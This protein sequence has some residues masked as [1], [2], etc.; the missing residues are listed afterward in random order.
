MLAVPSP[1]CSSLRH[2]AHGKPSRTIPIKCISCTLLLFAFT[3]R[4]LTAQMVPSGP[5]ANGIGSVGPN[6]LRVRQLDELSNE[7]DQKRIMDEPVRQRPPLTCI[8]EP[9]PGLSKTVSVHSLQVPE[10]VQNEYER[11]CTALRSK[12]LAESEKHLRKAVQYSPDAFG[13]VMLG[14][15]LEETERWD[16]ARN[17]CIEGVVHDP[18][19]WPA[20]ICLAEIDA[21]T[22]RW[23]ASLDESDRAVSLSL[24]SKRFAYFVSALALFNL[25]QVS[26]AESRALEAKRLDVDHQ[27]PPLHL[28]LAQIDELKG[29]LR[30]AETELHDCLKYAKDS[31]AGD[32]A[33]QEL[34]RLDSAAK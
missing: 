26:E 3:G 6:D 29:D 1:R 15:I 28:L 30:A 20:Q 17:A 7:I 34:A 9:F 33:K 32:M 13:W 19:Y 24:E 25:D 11:A 12:K 10:K 14:K 16:E 21:R 27:L 8:F 23:K 18:S 31:L 22:Q 4:P 5:D 2:F